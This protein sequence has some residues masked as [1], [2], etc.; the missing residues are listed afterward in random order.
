MRIQGKAH[1]FRA[2]ENI[3]VQQ[4]GAQPIVGI[5]SL[6]RIG[7]QEYP[8]YLLK[9]LL[10][11][12]MHPTVVGDMFLQYLHLAA[13]NTRTDITHPVIVTDF[14]M[15]VIGERLTCLGSIEHGLLLCQLVRDDQSSSAGSR[16]HLV[17]VKTQ[18]AKLAERAAFLPL[19]L[20]AQCLG[21][22]LQ[23]GNCITAGNLHDRIHLGWHAIKM[24]RN[25]RLRLLA[26]FCHA[27]LNR[28]FQQ[29]GI[30]VPRILLAVHK[31][32][33]RS[34]IGH[35]VC[36]SAKRKTLTNHFVPGTYTSLNQGKMH[37]RRTG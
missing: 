13:T 36:R 10:I 16:Y 21:C 33:G 31:H 7:F 14:L 34:Q 3:L 2:S 9:S 30:H 1:F 19:V 24:D 20:R 8:L 5:P 15:L 17:A 18:Y 37:C 35:G 26:C 4:Y 28:L 32:R 27:V 12:C 29:H 22:I 25:Y 23:H 11:K 6:A